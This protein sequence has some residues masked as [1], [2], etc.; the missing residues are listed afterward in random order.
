MRCK[1]VLAYDGSAFEGLQIQ[2]HT[3]NT[4]ANQLQIALQK[5]QID[6]KVIF[7]GRTD[8]GVHATYQVCHIDLPKFWSDFQKLQN[9]LNQML[10]SSIMIRSIKKAAPNFHARYHATKRL[11]RY[12]L[13][14]KKPNPFEARFITFVNDLDF[15]EIE[16]KIQ[17]FEGEH[18]FVSFSKSGSNPKTTLRTI[19]KTACYKYKE[20][21]ILTFEA[22]AFLRSQIRLMVAAL[23]E[24]KAAEIEAMLKKE[25]HFKLKPA[26][27][28]GLYLAKIYY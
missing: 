6:S 8:K 25:Q 7:S 23:L 15:H 3:Q 28:N 16:K 5:L 2:K 24:L 14:T 20:Y 13:S 26:P 17:L 22:N 9:S 10:P 18:D 1:I 27:P 12:I 21:I 19:Y 4:V 11:Y